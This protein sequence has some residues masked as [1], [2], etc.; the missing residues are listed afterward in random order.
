[1]FIMICVTSF[2]GTIN[3]V[4]GVEC[5]GEEDTYGYYVWEP[6]SGD[7]GAATSAILRTLQMT[8]GYLY[9]C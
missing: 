8:G 6:T 9:S 7:G 5:L 4:A 1:M 2:S 3:A